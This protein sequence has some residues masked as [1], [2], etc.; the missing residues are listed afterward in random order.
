MLKTTTLALAALM[1]GSTGQATAAGNESLTWYSGTHAEAIEEAQA[2]EQFTFTY[3]WAAT[4]NCSRT[5]SETMAD[6]LVIAEMNEMVCFSAN[7][8]EDAG[9]ALLDEYRLTTVPAM[10]LIGPDGEAEEMLLGFI[11]ASTFV[12]EIQRIKRGENTLSGLRAQIAGEHEELEQELAQ[13]KMLSEK[14]GL[15]GLE[16]ESEAQLAKILARDP[17]GG[18]ETGARVGTARIVDEIAQ[19]GGEDMASWDLD[20]LKKYAKKIK[21]PLGRFEG[22]VTLGGLELGGGHRSDGLKTYMVAWKDR[23]EEDAVVNTGF[24]MLDQL[25]YMGEEL[26]TSEKRFGLRVA[27]D[28][29]GLVETLESRPRAACAACDEGSEGKGEG[30]AT[31]KAGGKGA[32]GAKGDKGDKGCC[33]EDEGPGMRPYALY[34]VARFQDLNGERREA[35]ATM[36]QCLELQPDE[37]TYA[38][39]LAELNG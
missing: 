3:F 9:R 25:A 5:Y 14:L 36:G 20:P 34:Q 23:P 22:R 6:A 28:L 11:D 7:A 39:Y 13:R 33:G 15:M 32:K 12:N 19:A 1:I 21:H 27:E 2:N 30:Q 29:V 26:S 24:A 8:G 10:L 35:V 16:D 17:K 37:E 4:E 31:A 18:T 38:A